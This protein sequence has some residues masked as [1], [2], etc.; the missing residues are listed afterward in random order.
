MAKI[1]IIDDD[2]MMN[3]ALA[4]AV[5]DLGHETLSAL[6]LEQGLRK[7]TADHIDAVFLDVRLPDGSGIDAIARIRKNPSRPEV[8]IITGFGDRNGA[9]LAIR[10]GAW[11]Y[12][13]KPC[14]ADEMILPLRRALEYRQARQTVSPHIFRRNGIVGTGS[15]ISEA[16]R[17]SAQ[18]A[19]GDMPVLLYG[20]TGTGKELFARAIHASSSR[21]A[22]SFVTVDCG[23]LPE[24][25]AESLLFGHEKG[26]FTGADKKTEGQI[27]K[28]DG[29]TLFLDEIGELPLSVQKTFLRV[30]QER[31]FFP[32][33]SEKMCISNFRIVAASNR[34]PDQMVHNGMFRSDLLFRI[35]GFSITLPPLRER[36]EDI[37]ELLMHFVNRVCESL[38]ADTKGFTAEFLQMLCE[39][40]WPGNVREFLHAVEESL[41]RAA[42]YPILYPQHLPPHIRVHI[43]QKILP[44]SPADL[45]SCAAFVPVFSKKGNFPSLKKVR[46]DMEKHYLRQLMHHVQGKR[47]EACRISGL[48][49]SRLFELLKKYGTE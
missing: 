18:A 43:A 35:R 20:E 37:R 49:R 3:M 19:A 44:E 13:Q 34:N 2:E 22:K 25:L 40:D 30:L 16:I 42:D 41:A 47:N 45:D 6:T 39:Y 46:A 14:T 28:A 31:S 11:D 15:G 10:N 48:S 33:G 4:R 9:E 12:I 1:L 36:K 29:G 24:S 7:V 23:A 5:S 26:S 27:A 8:I 17:L 21:C 32:V 38:S